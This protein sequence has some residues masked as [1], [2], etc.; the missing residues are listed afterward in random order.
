MALKPSPA[1]ALSCRYQWI[2]AASFS[3]FANSKADLDSM[4]QCG[5]DQASDSAR[6]RVRKPLFREGCG[7]SG[8]VRQESLRRQHRFGGE[9][10][11]QIPRQAV[12]ESRQ[13][14][15]LRRGRLSRFPGHARKGLSTLFHNYANVFPLI[16]SITY[17]IFAANRWGRICGCREAARFESSCRPT[18]RGS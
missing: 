8:S 2:A 12:Q 6:D 4:S 7:D 1:I 11:R 16:S 9:P 17:G 5:Q 15:E 3:S 14:I 18:K 10:R 13:L